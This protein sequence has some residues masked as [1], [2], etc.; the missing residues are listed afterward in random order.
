MQF[1]AG[2]VERD[3]AATLH[4]ESNDPQKPF[5]DIPLVAQ[6]RQAPVAVARLRS[7]DQDPLHCSVAG[8][9]HPL[10]IV[11]LDGSLSYDQHVPPILISSYLWTVTESPLGTDP[12]LFDPHGFDAV[13]ADFVLPL[14]GRYLVHLQ[15]GNELGILS[16]DSPA[17][18]VEILAVPKSRIHI[19]LTWD[20]PTNDQD[21]H[22]T[23][24]ALNDLVCDAN[25][26]CFWG[27]CKPTCP[28][29]EGCRASP[30]DWFPP[31]QPRE[32][33]NPRLDIDDTHGLGPENINIDVPAAGHYNVYVHYYGL[34]DLTDTPTSDMLRIYVDGQLA[35]E[36]RRTLSRNDLWRVA[37]IQWNDDGSAAV[38]AAGSDGGGIGQVKTMLSCTQGFAFGPWY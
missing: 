33:P 19:Q 10:E 28:G 24:A 11:Y 7:C 29:G 32:G 27:N 35:A 17:S 3:G 13:M 2:S 9:I 26:D 5:A 4:I 34:V 6:A 23:T 38:I 18:D 8:D 22:L 37:E 15:V 30:P 12:A 36:Y 25:A 20:H 16:G 31:A 21:V 1:D 14:A